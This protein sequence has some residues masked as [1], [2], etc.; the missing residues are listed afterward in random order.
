M[1]NALTGSRLHMKPTVN[2]PR[3]KSKRI[4]FRIKKKEELF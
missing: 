1:V 3:K 2:G 4:L